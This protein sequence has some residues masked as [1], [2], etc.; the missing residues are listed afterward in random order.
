MW[1][2]GA[3]AILLLLIASPLPSILASGDRLSQ[4]PSLQVDAAAY[5]AIAADIVHTG[6]LGAIPPLQPP[7]FV[8]LLSGVYSLPVPSRVAARVALWLCFV[9]CV[10]LAGLLA[11]MV[12]RDEL[13]GWAAALL[14]ASSAMLRRYTGTIQYELVAALAVLILIVL[15]HRFGRAERGAILVRGAVALGVAAGLAVLVREVLS[16]IVP[17]LALFVRQR[18][19]AGARPWGSALPG[20]IV[21][22]VS[23]AVVLSWIGVQSWRSDRIVPLSD[24]GPLVLAFGNNPHANG[25]F[26]APLA[27]VGDPAG[28]SFMAAYPADTLRLA[29]RKIL[30]FWGILRDGWNVPRVSAIWMARSTAGLVPLEWWLPFARGGAVLAAVLVALWLWPRALWREWWLLPASILAVLCVHVVTVSSHRFIAPVLP[31]AFVISAGPAAS[32]T[33]WVAATQRRLMLAGVLIAASMAMQLVRWPVTYTLRAAAMDGA[34]AVDGWDAQE[35]TIRVADASRGPRAVALLADEFLP[36]GSFAVTVTMRAMG[37]GAPPAA[38]MWLQTIE[39]VPVCE[40]DIDL[41]ARDRWTEVSMPCVLPAD[42]IAT[43]ALETT[44]R[45]DLQIARVSFGWDR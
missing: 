17:L 19:P 1:R 26:N 27:G 41:E 11:S 2:L 6:S 38:R 29:G 24:K 10:G 42:S 16:V 13:A 22:I 9:A 45:A 18:S 21:A 31:L 23:A 8:T 12:Y 5:D 7:G 40:R 14:T 25:T 37:S 32:A 4:L 3:A 20:I 36:R 34:N 35:G 30:Y 28:I 39:G 43:F 44:G 33:R 15:A